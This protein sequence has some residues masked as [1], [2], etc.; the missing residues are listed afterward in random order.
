MDVMIRI[1]W[2]VLAV[3]VIMLHFGHKAE[4]SANGLLKAGFTIID[5]QGNE[6]EHFD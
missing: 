1:G 6:V 3:V 4:Q 2:L 5:P